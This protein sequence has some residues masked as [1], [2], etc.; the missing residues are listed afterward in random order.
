MSRFDRFWKW[1]IYG[2]PEWI[3]YV[4]TTAVL[5]VLASALTVF[6]ALLTSFPTQTFLGVVVLAIYVLKIV[7]SMF[8]RAEA[9]KDVKGQDDE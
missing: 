2:A 6:M 7:W 5:V 3:G 8:L 1:A 9:R 4:V